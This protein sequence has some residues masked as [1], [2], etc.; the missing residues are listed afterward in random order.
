MVVAY[1]GHMSR[2]YSFANSPDT[3]QTPVSAGGAA[4]SMEQDGKYRGE[5][6]LYAETRKHALSA[7]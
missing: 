2:S 7:K 4:I 1:S 6:D 5:L 3:T